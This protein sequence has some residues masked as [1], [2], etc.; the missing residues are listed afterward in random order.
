MGGG[1]AETDSI[2]AL[3]TVPVKVCLRTGFFEPSLAGA[4][5]VEAS[6]TEFPLAGTRVSLYRRR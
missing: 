1:D 4:G 2:L 6:V 3:L 5:F